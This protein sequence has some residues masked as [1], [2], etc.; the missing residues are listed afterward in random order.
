MTRSTSGSR[1]AGSR[2]SRSS[3]RVKNRKKKKT[4]SRITGRQLSMVI[5]MLLLF[6][7]SGLGY[8]WS[9][10]EQTQIGYDLSELKK[11]EMK[12]MEMNRK[13]R[14][15]IAMRKSTFNLEK[16]A[17]DKLGLKQPTIKQVIVL[18]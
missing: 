17:V 1:T 16:I 2:N 7:G 13:L 6:M 18:P 11:R 4:E 15:E 5:L 10:Y 3:I 9:N 8:V 14:V 12:L